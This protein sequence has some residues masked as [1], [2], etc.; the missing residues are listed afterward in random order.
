MNYELPISPNYVS[1]WSIKEA[2]REILQNAIDSDKNG[3]KKEISYNKYDKSLHIKNYG[4]TLSTSTLVLGCSSKKDIDGMIG[5]FGEGYKLALVVLL[6][7][8]YIV[9][10]INGGEIWLP[11]F[12]DRLRSR[13]THPYRW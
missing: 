6:R 12:K 4:I 8:G 9:N 2:I 1:N 7:E 11:S 13:R 10:I 3:Y 5:K